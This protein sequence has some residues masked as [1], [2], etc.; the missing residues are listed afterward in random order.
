MSLSYLIRSVKQSR[1]KMNVRSALNILFTLNIIFSD[2]EYESDS[3]S[4]DE[5][6]DDRQLSAEHYL[7]LA[8]SFD[9]AQLQQKQYSLNTQE[10][11][12][13]TCDY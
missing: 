7:T 9:I 6:N 8:E 12:N 2:S 11:L 5:E 13:E 3:V 1:S 10:K 4:N